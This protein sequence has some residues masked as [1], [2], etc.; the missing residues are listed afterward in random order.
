ML[1]GESVTNRDFLAFKLHACRAVAEELLSG[2][3]QTRAVSHLARSHFL[4]ATAALAAGAAAPARAQTADKIDVHH[5]YV[6]PA[7]VRE[8]GSA[9]LAP[10]I[11]GWTLEKSMDDMD[12]AGVRRAYLSITTP[13]LDFGF[14][15]STK[16]LA[17]E[18]NAYAADVVQRYPQRYGMFT[19]LPLP[20]VK[21]SLEEVAYG[22]DTLKADGVGMF[23]S[24]GGHL[25]LGDARLDP[26]FAELDRRKA[27]VFVHPTSNACCTN[28]LGASI[29]DSMIEY[30]TDTTRAIA[31]YLFNGAAKRFPNVRIIWSHAGG[32][33]PYLIGRFL[34]K[35]SSPDW[36]AMLP[37]TVADTVARFY[38]DT[39]Q[40]ANIEA[41]T[42]LT[43]LVPASHV[44]FGTDFPYSVSA[45]DVAGLQSSGFTDGQLR[46]VFSGNA[47][48]LLNR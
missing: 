5:H 39:A 21:A 13:G 11:L 18:C 19:A 3:R 15:D 20:D 36:A 26:L 29:E 6:P 44:L 42:A 43:K 37:G 33:M 10:P 40:S 48:A 45:R 30:Q 38:Y 17:R 1:R 25:W 31:N 16:R 23:S 9:A 7:Y 28:L 2:S 8:V 32:T 27:L 35:A 22:L 14:P 24:Y 4:A 46:G 34:R 41:M 47:V 12:R